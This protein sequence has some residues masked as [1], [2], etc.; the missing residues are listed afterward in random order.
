MAESI[1]PET[2]FAI[3][4]GAVCFGNRQEVRQ[5]A[6][7]AVQA[8]SC[9]E[10]GTGGGGGGGTVLF[11]SWR[12]NF[13]ALNG[14]WNVYR[15][16]GRGS[17]VSAAFCCHEG[18]VSP[19]AEATRILQVANSPYA[20]DGATNRNTPK[21]WQGRVV[22]IN[23]YDWGED[24][25]TEQADGIA[26]G[27]QGLVGNGQRNSRWLVDYQHASCD[28]QQWCD[29][30]HGV[31]LVIFGEYMFG[32]FGLVEDRSCVHSFLFFTSDTE[33][34]NT[35]FRTT[36]G[37]SSQPIYIPLTPQERHAKRLADGTYSGYDWVQTYLVNNHV[38]PPNLAGPFMVTIV[39]LHILESI[40]QAVQP[41]I[42]VFEP[43]LEEEMV[44][45]L[46]ECLG[47]WIAMTLA[48]AAESATSRE[49][50]L[51]T[52]FPTT[53]TT[54]TGGTGTPR[55]PARESNH[56]ANSMILK[57]IRKDDGMEVSLPAL[58]EI[59]PRGSGLW[60]FVTVR[61]ISCGI[62]YLLHEILELAGKC[63]RDGN[64]S[65]LVTGDIRMAIG[66]DR[67]LVDMGLNAAKLFWPPDVIVAV[68]D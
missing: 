55:G 4:S 52:A 32:R 16:V 24:Y 59:A 66:S 10:F 15:L 28:V 23:R 42:P 56:V 54:A 14:R 7:A 20:E 38:V 45:L 39:P 62:C 34:A 21:T 53:T 26:A 22:V 57:A 65:V 58:H 36:T 30:R 6:Q 40:L 13:A 33:L 3:S 37:G 17:V 63:A 48:P 49:Q 31:R 35:V 68:E 64:R 50:F 25:Y 60:N 18:L 2:S 9:P 41:S 12:Y 67:E 11:H 44:Q 1:T 47:A 51:A 29:S 43:Q 19:H 27:E 61:E 46:S 8:P 5:G